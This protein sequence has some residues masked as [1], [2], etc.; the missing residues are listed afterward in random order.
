M[1]KRLMPHYDKLLHVLVTFA[2]MMF[3]MLWLQWRIVTLI[4]FVLQALKWVRNWNVQPMWVRFRDWLPAS[5]LDWLA[6]LA[7]YGLVALY[8]WLR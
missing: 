2:L 3:G 5:L 4:V 8:I 1:F 6:N 7:G